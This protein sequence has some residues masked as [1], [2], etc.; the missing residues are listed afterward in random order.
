MWHFRAPHPDDTKPVDPPEAPTPERSGS[1][2]ATMVIIM[3][4]AGFVGTLLFLL[5]LLPK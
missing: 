5:N 3:T 1:F 4:I 2:W